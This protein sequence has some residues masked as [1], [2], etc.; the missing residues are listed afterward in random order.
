MLLYN[1]LVIDVV[2]ALGLALE[3]QRADAMRRP[4]R[5]TDQ[6]IIDRP[7]LQRILLQG[8]LI[9]LVGAI[10]FEVP[11]L[12]W[13]VELAVAQ[14]TAFVAARGAQIL[15][16]VNHRGDHGSGFAGISGSRALLACV[17][18]TVGLEAL[19]L[20]LPPLRDILGLTTLGAREWA[21]AAGLTLVPLIVVQGLRA[22]RPRG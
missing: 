15:S 5:P 16:V 11:L 18:L 12:V 4:P 20:F 9:F 8:L 14:T 19:A 22:A 2:P 21:S 13:G 6:P 17:A 1:N 7:T 10:A 3:P